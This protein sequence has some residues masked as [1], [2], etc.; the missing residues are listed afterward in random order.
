M[1]KKEE[2]VKNQAFETAAQLRDEIKAEKEK[3]TDLQKKWEDTRE[4]EKVTLT[5]DDVAS[6]LAKMTGIPLFR[7]EEG[8]SKRLLR[9]EE[10]LKKSIVGQEEAITVLSRTLRRARAGLGDPRRPIGTFLFLGPTGVGKTELARSLA[11]FLFDDAEA[12]IRIDMS[13]YMEKFAV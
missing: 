5:A 7:L 10:E 9:M 8:E 1:H 6:V 4:K 11:M 2:S 12:L 13:E 3:L